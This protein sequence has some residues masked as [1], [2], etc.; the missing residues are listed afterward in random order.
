M[1]LTLLRM[2][3]FRFSGR[4][5]RSCTR[6]YCRKVQE[7]DMRRTLTCAMETVTL[8]IYNGANVPAGLVFGCTLQLYCYTSKEHSNT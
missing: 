6:M 8:H 1:L 5:S 4:K 7:S 2:V 3:I